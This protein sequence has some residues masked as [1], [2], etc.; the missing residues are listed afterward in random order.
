MDFELLTYIEKYLLEELDAQE[1]ALFEKRLE[2]DVEF[3]KA[4]H[5]YLEQLQAELP[6]ERKGMHVDDA[7]ASMEQQLIAGAGEVAIS[8]SQ[9]T[10]RKWAAA[11]S[12]FLVMGAMAY[13]LGQSTH[14]AR[15]EMLVK[16][17]AYG[18]KSTITLSDGSTVR[19]NSGSKL[20]YP[21]EFGDS[22]RLVVLEGEAFF[23]VVPDADRPFLIRSG[24]LTTKVLGTSFNIHAFPED[25]IQQVAVRTGTV[26]VYVA[27]GDLEAITLAPGKVAHFVKETG[28]WKIETVDPEHIAYWARGYLY[29]DNEPLAEVL[30]ELGRWYGVV[31]EVEDPAVLN[32]RITLKQR[33]ENLKNI[34]NIIKFATHVNYQFKS[35]KVIIQGSAC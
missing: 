4:Y 22:S 1:T 33:D 35:N 14:P 24:E 9:P 18:Q 5:H 6:S 25:D 10:F 7:W 27:D 11:I 2:E 17:T 26:Q 30:K 16:T 13:W 20:T 3:A 23:D 34:L 8:D 21:K 29:F 31:I 19:L 28:N 15:P 32:C 12:V